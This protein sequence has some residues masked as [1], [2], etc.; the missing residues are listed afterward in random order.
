M[1]DVVFDRNFSFSSSGGGLWAQN[2][3]TIIRGQFIRNRSYCPISPVPVIPIACNGGGGFY[4]T[5]TIPIPGLAMMPHLTVSGSRFIGNLAGEQGGGLQ[6]NGDATINNSTLT[7]NVAQRGG[8]MAVG[9]LLNSLIKDRI[10]AANTVQLM[11]VGAQMSS[12]EVTNTILTDNVARQSGGGIA[13]GDGSNLTLNN[14][15]V[16][17]NSAPQGREAVAQPGSFVDVD[18]SNTIGYGENPGVVG[19]APGPT[20]TV[21]P[22]PPPDPVPDAS[23]PP[24]PPVTAQ[25]PPSTEEIPPPAQEPPPQ[26]ELPPQPNAGNPSDA[27]N[28][29]NAGPG[30]AG[31]ARNYELLSGNVRD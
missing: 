30:N 22:Q 28:A 25:L 21:A 5:G 14:T 23:L 6:I 20:D 17:G 19:F 24:P 16:S 9:T 13:V 8:A 12:V 26:A 1:V 3:V 7:D 15:V 27:G 11:D 29:G 31:N 2:M 10:S 18:N 4:A